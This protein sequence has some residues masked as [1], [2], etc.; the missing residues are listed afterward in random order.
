VWNAASPITYTAADRST[1]AFQIYGR[2]AANQDVPGGTTYSDTV[3]VTV[4]Y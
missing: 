3:T 2:I 4:N 1:T